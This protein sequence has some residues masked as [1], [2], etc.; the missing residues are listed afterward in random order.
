MNWGYKILFVYL[1]FVAAILFLVYKASEE[2]VDMVTSDY[3]TKELQYQKKI[4][5][6]E[7]NNALTDTVAYTIK[8]HELKINFPGKFSGKKIE[9]S[10]LLYCPSN[11]DKDIKNNFIIQDTVY[12]LS[13]PAG[14]TGL[15]QLQLTWQADSLT[16]YLERKLIL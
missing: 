8:N 14:N 13:L 9:G 6:A 3:Y 11:E 4:D 10:I 2:K 1:I 7:R 15:H 16:Y 12:T 5:Q